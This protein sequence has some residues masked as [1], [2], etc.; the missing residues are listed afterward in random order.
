MGGELDVHSGSARHTRKRKWEIW[1]SFWYFFP[2]ISSDEI[3]KIHNINPKGEKILLF[4][5]GL[6]WRG[7]NGCWV[8]ERCEKVWGNDWSWWKV[9]RMLKLLLHPQ[10]MDSLHKN[11]SSRFSFPCQTRMKHKLWSSSDALSSSAEGE[12]TSQLSKCLQK[13]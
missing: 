7:W 8:T 1:M 5:H 13:G 9:F 10:L 2:F 4:C 6:C 12:T 11:H 3:K